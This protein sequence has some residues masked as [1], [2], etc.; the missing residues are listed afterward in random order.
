MNILFTAVGRRVSLLRSFR[1][2]MNALCIDGKII[3]ADSALSAP[4]LFTADDNVR[5]P[6]ADSPEYI[7]SLLSVCESYKVDLLIPLI[8]TDL[9]VLSR[10]KKAFSEKGITLIVC[11]TETN[12][13]CFDKLKTNEFFVKNY[14]NSPHVYSE[15]E[16]KSIGE[17]D[18]PVIIKPWD[19]SCSVGVNVV[20]S[21]SEFDFFMKNTRH[22]MAQALVLG[23]EYTCDA[24]VDFNGVVRCVVPRRRLETRAGEVSKGLTVNDPTI[25]EAVSSCINS[26]PHA[27]GCMT[28]QCFRLLDGSVSFIEINPRFGGGHPLSIQAGADFPKWILQEFI[29]GECDA[30]FDAWESDL[31]MLRYDE[32]VFVAGCDIQ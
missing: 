29:S 25:I 4:A 17:A 13:I 11:D 8:D 16:L 3:A 7:F 14:I 10:H 24:Y 5:I 28:V 2:A 9:A 32:E 30:S 20:H 19:G 18:F 26:L 12:L 1:R 22:A 21:F 6:R 15:V 27:I 23:D 31:A